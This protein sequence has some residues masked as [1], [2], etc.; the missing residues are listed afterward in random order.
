[1]SVP[2][3]LVDPPLQAVQAFLALAAGIGGGNVLDARGTLAIAQA[4]QPVVVEPELSLGAAPEL[5]GGAVPGVD[6][7][8]IDVA[9]SSA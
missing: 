4:H 8:G 2:H 1:M 5:G 3:Q 9:P 6:E 7:L